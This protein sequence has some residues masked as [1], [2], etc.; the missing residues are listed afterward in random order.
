MNS[1]YSTVQVENK[2][3]FGETIY[4]ELKL[5]GRGAWNRARR[6]WSLLLLIFNGFGLNVLADVSI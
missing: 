2:N 5:R 4:G 3:D 1:S 6:F